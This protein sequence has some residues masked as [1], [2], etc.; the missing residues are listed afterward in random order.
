MPQIHCYLPEELVERL[1]LKA[2]AGRLAVSR[3]VAQVI[4]KDLHNQ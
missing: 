3:Y 4:R 2:R 1:H